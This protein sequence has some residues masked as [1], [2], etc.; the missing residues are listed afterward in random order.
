MKR[1]I[2]F[3]EEAEAELRAAR[4]W[5]EA[6]RKGLGMEFLLC[7]EATLAAI[8]RRPEQFR[9]LRG[10]IRRAMVRRFPF[11]ILFA[12]DD[13]AVVVLSVFHGS[14]DPADWQRRLD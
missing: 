10:E 14:R 7:I 13:E 12:A 2:R 8:A 9:Q 1:T 3:R 11:A 6:R 5:Y 4:E